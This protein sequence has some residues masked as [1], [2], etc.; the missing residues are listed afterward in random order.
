MERITFR[1]VVLRFVFRQ[2]TSSTFVMT[3]KSRYQTPSIHQ[4]ILLHD[5]QLD[6]NEHLEMLRSLMI[7]ILDLPGLFSNAR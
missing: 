4:V 7:S 1:H 6:N 5:L 2:S 3:Y